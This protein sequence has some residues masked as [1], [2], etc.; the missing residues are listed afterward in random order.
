MCCVVILLCR[1]KQKAQQEHLLWKSLQGSTDGS[2]CHRVPREE[3]QGQ[4]DAG[5]TA[6]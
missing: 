1:H 4:R 6:P 3:A 5:K 2:G